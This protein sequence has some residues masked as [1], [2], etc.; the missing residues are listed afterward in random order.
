MSGWWGWGLILPVEKQKKQ[1]RERA[2]FDFVLAL[3]DVLGISR[4]SM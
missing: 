3:R 2:G 1:I 4:T